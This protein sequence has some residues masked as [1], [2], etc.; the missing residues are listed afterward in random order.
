LI[1]GSDFSAQGEEVDM[2]LAGL[3]RVIVQSVLPAAGSGRYVSFAID[4]SGRGENFVALVDPDPH[5]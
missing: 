1:S 3:V 4:G 2:P 5:D